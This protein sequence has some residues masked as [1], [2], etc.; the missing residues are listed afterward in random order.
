M[1]RARRVFLLA[2]I[3]ADAG[4]A[5]GLAPLADSLAARFTDRPD[6]K[7]YRASALFLSGRTEDALAARTVLSAIGQ[8]A[9]K[10]PPIL[11]KR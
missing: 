3:V 8:S 1:A 5:G 4:D 11:R 10:R 9:G 6:P 7:Y 2:S